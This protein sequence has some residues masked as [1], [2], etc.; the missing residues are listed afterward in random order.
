MEIVGWRVDQMRWKKIIYCGEQQKEE[1]A[2]ANI[3]S[4][5]Q[6][7]RKL[8]SIKKK[9][10]ETRLVLFLFV[11]YIF[12]PTVTQQT[13]NVSDSSLQSVKVKTSFQHSH[14]SEADHGGRECFDGRRLD[15][16][17]IHCPL[18]CPAYFWTK[19]GVEKK[20]HL[21]PFFFN[22][23]KRLFLL[24]SQKD[25]VLHSWKLVKAS[26]FSEAEKQWICQLSLCPQASENAAA[27]ETEHGY[28]GM[29][30][31]EASGPWKRNLKAWIVTKTEI[32]FYIFWQ[33]LK[34]VI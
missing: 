7:C 1:M 34:G 14:S 20:K 4:L 12:I 3:V 19:R 27:L 2:L 29:L 28:K 24:P 13:S 16:R 5:N 33:K 21:T 15:G 32:Q 31:W 25:W 11:V 9:K 23:K 26:R 10:D 18:H 8:I 30:S 17:T 22:L 6:H